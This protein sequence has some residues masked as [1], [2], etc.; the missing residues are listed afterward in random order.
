VVYT[1]VR[2]TLTALRHASQLGNSLHASLRI[3]VPVVVPYPLDL[4]SPPVDSRIVSR[5]LK[6]VANGTR[7][8]TL[9]HFLYCRDRENAVE[10]SLQPHSIVVICWRKRWLFDR[11]SGL[12]RRLATLGHQ[13]VVVPSE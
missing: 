3:V 11:T 5:S 6:T 8:P 2:H 12:A 9:I 1:D 7:I 10:R 4:A 13:V